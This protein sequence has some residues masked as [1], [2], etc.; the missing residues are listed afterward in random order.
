MKYPSF[1]GDV[2]EDLFKFK[3]KM[4][5]CF[6]KNRVPRSDMTDKLRENLKG[7]AFKRVPETVKDIDVAWKN[8]IEAFGSPMVVLKERLKSLTKLGNV[9]P[10]SLPSKQIIWYHDF[11]SIIQDIIDL[12]TTAD[13]NLQMGAFGP[14]VQEM[15][16]KALS[17]NPLK[18]RDVAKAGHGM[19]PRAKMLAFCEVHF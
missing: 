8:L 15:V 18:K 9:P 10:D 4:V 19:K 3:T 17:D 2:G 5:E 12:G 16:L 6:H 7:G 1:S 11:E 14:P 13:L